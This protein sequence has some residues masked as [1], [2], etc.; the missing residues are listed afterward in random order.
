MQFLLDSHAPPEDILQFCPDLIQ[1]TGME[2][3]VKS[4]NA[5]FSIEIFESPL[6]KIV[7]QRNI[8]NISLGLSGTTPSN[9]Y[10]GFSQVRVTL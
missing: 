7:E 8:W 4:S 6:A 2:Q 1:G 9:E 3:V 10:G 5:G